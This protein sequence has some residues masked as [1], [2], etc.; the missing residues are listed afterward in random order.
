MV[1]VVLRVR[2]A[3]RIGRNFLQADFTAKQRYNFRRRRNALPT[4]P[5]GCDDEYPYDTPAKHLD[6]PQSRSRATVLQIDIPRFGSALPVAITDA[7]AGI[8]PYR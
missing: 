7:A 6:T 2:H 8:K 5:Q 1:D 4:R 3:D